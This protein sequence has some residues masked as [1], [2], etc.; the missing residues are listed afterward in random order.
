MSSMRLRLLLS[1]TIIGSVHPAL[2]QT[3]DADCPAEI[4]AFLVTV[5]ADEAY[6]RIAPTF[7]ETEAGL[8]AAMRTDG[9]DC[10]VVLRDA[11]RSLV[12]AGVVVTGAS[13]DASVERVA[14]LIDGGSS[15]EVEPTLRTVE[16]VPQSAE[17]MDTSEMAV[18]AVEPAVPGTD[19]TDAPDTD[20]PDV[21]AAPD[22][23][24]VPDASAPDAAVAPID[25]PSAESRPE[26]R[27]V[28]PLESATTTDAGAQDVMTREV[29]FGFDSADVPDDARSDVLP[30]VAG[31]VG[32]NP[33]TAV[34]LTGHA[35]P[36]GNADYNLRLSERRVTAVAAALQAL[37]VPEAAISTRA[38]GEESPE[39][40]AAE[41]EL[42]EENRRVEIRV[43]VGGTPD[44]S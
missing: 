6:S 7:G 1:V 12:D 15:T 3:A 4:A 42:S 2:A 23:A 16:V 37:G 8:D 5:R 10:L 14:L 36:I 22:V 20:V 40:P 34:L 44:R 28:P 30:E 18:V 29:E 26:S 21:A 19:A 17:T 35:S 38:Q 11:Q 27:P 43:V 41:D 24:A 33:G 32:S 13:D 39:V 9:A 31:M 25:V